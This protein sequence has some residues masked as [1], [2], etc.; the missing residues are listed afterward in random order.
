MGRTKDDYPEA[1]R[2]VCVDFYAL[3]DSRLQ[4]V[5]ERYSMGYQVV[6]DIE[7]LQEQILTQ[8]VYRL[9][10]RWFGRFTGGTYFGIMSAHP[11]YE[12]CPI[13]GEESIW[14]ALLKYHG[15]FKGG[16]LV[17]RYNPKSPIDKWLRRHTSDGDTPI[18]VETL[19][20]FA[21]RSFLERH[22]F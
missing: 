16:K 4:D 15:K 17:F 6:Y 20:H 5:E 2:D 21:T 18:N 14:E 1:L 8:D 7:A 3:L 12:S 19:F 22:E 10:D 11:W 9:S 13:Q